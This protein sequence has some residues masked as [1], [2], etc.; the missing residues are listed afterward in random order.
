VKPK[1]YKAMGHYYVADN[2][3][4]V[5]QMLRCDYTRAELV[6]E[7]IETIAGKFKLI[8]LSSEEEFEIDV[9]D[10][11]KYFTAPCMLPEA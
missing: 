1:L 4:H 10:I 3:A 11:G 6:K 8:N 2:P 9:K 5:R 7:K